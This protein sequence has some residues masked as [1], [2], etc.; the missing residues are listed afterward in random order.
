MHE[1]IVSG[2]SGPCE[3][4]DNVKTEYI[5]GH[6]SKSSEKLKI[7]IQPLKDNRMA[8]RVRLIQESVLPVKY[9]DTFYE[10]I[11]DSSLEL[12][13]MAYC[14]DIPVGVICCRLEYIK[15]QESLTT[16]GEK[17]YALKSESKEISSGTSQKNGP[18]R[19]YI[20]TLA[21]LRAYRRL[22]VATKLFY[23]LMGAIDKIS[24]E[25]HHVAEIALH[26]Q[27]GNDEALSFYRNHGF[28]I[29][30][31]VSNYYTSVEPADALW[32]SRIYSRN[33]STNV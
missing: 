33:I 9:S 28:Q 3:T 21:V 16:F 4:K 14:N 23:R 5:P 27:V 19:C 11:F 10:R 17:E 20:M 31:I 29:G 6:D 1:Q 8:F 26:V 12:N 18:L 30:E 22:G 2:V 25:E 24:S 32:V 7:R 15:K 13:Y